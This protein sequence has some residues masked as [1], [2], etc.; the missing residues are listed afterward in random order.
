MGAEVYVST[1]VCVGGVHVSVYV[2]GGGSQQNTMS[3][4]LL[5]VSK[6]HH[7][8]GDSAS[9]AASVS[10]ITAAATTTGSDNLHYQGPPQAQSR[11]HII[12]EHQNQPPGHA[13]CK[14]PIH[15]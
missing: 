14:K 10:N 12:S 2:W 13:G 6:S 9:G 8:P 3:L 4:L 7:V 11:S 15:N 5:R 1:C